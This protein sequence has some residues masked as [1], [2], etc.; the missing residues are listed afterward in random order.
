M[1]E[2]VSEVVKAG[3]S[4]DPNSTGKDDSQAPLADTAKFNKYLEEKKSQYMWSRR[5]WSFLHNST[6]FLSIILSSAAAVISQLDIGPEDIGTGREALQKNLTTITAAMA[7]L[8]LGLNSAGR[9]QAK[10]QRAR[11]SNSEIE[12]LEVEV[13]ET[14]LSRAHSAKLKQIIESHDSGI[15]GV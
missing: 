13:S 4:G 2:N 14:T 15:A 9:F 1:S 5:Y 11:I 12:R 7:A 6:T 10:W 8:L 3:G